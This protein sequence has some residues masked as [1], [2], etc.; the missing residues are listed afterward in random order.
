LSLTYFCSNFSGCY[1]GW[2]AKGYEW[3]LNATK[4]GIASEKDYKY[5]IPPL[6]NCFP[7]PINKAYCGSPDYCN[8]TCNM[9][10]P[11]SVFI[12]GYE[13]VTNPDED[14]IAQYLMEHGPLSIALNA[15][16]MQFYHSGISNPMYCPP[17]LD[18][19]V[20]LVGFGTKTGLFG[21]IEKYWII[22]NSWGESWG[23]KGYYLLARG[24]NG[25]C[26]VNKQVVRPLV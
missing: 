20:L 6:G 5:C 18:H 16:W 24:H 25:K 7:C 2:P 17:D 4:G 19:A 1:G 13:N 11:S 23:E 9:H 14:Y 10:A 26:G 8:V 3:L 12:T 15:I 22:K 21:Q